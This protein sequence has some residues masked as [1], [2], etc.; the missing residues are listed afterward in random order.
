MARFPKLKAFGLA[1]LVTG[2]ILAAAMVGMLAIMDQ[3]EPVSQSQP[4]VPM[5]QYTPTAEDNLTVLLMFGVDR[6]EA[7]T[8]Y[9]LLCFTPETG[10]VEIVPLPPELT[11]TVNIRTDTLSGHYRYGSTDY[12]CAAVQ[13]ALKI[14][15]DRY[16]LLN[17]ESG[18]ALIDLVGGVEVDVAE[19]IT[20]YDELRQKNVSINAGYQLLDGEKWMDLMCDPQ[21]QKESGQM[22]YL[23]AQVL[24]GLI[25]QFFTEE[26]VANGRAVFSAAID[27]VNTNLNQFDYTRRME[28]LEYFAK[29]EIKTEIITLEGEYGENKYGEKT[30]T[31]SPES[32]GVMQNLVGKLG[33]D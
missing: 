29:Q 14:P 9:Q 26:L 18:A 17:A 22:P 27:L 31:P 19:D 28:A 16:I 15:V 8:S 1:F 6:T 21:S 33:E 7:P 20:Y 32:K 13:N 10:K 11:S 24:A 23:R 12:V 5:E 25:E 30:F 3:A 2:V 4:D